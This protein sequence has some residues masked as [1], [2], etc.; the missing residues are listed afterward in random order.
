MKI[1]INGDEIEEKDKDTIHFDGK[2]F[3]RYNRENKY[4]SKNNIKRIIYKCIK[5]RRNENIKKDLNTKGFRYA[6]IIYIFPNQNKKS[7]Y[8]LKKKHSL[9]CEESYKIKLKK[10]IMLKTIKINLLI[11][12]KYDEFL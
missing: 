7:G 10:M 2:I 1:K 8:F 5:Y 4:R 11:L 9:E 3:K 6:T 12:R